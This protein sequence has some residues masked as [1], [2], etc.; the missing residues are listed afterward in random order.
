M[1]DSKNFKELYIPPLIHLI[2]LINHDPQKIIW[3]SFSQA[4]QVVFVGIFICQYLFGDV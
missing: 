1:L 4:I 3:T 2:L